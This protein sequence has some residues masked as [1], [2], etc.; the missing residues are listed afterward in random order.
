M[1]NP[2][3]LNQ[4]KTSPS[5]RENTSARTIALLNQKGGVGKTTTTINL[6]AALALAEQRVLLVDLDPQAHLM[7]HLG[8]DEA[9]V[10]HT[11]YDLLIDPEVKAADAIVNARPNLD[12]LLSEVDLAGAEPELA[13]RPDRQQ[14]LK[15]KIE[16]ILD[17]YDVIL[18]DCPPSLGLMTLNALACAREV[19]VPMQAHFLALQGVSKLLETVGL[20]CQSVNP[21]LRVSGIILCMHEAQTTL[22]KE[23][24]TDLEDFFEQASQQDVPWSQCR[25]LQPPIRRNIKLAEAPSFGETIFDYSPWCKG[26]IDYRKLARQLV[27]H[28]HRVIAPTAEVVEPKAE[29]PIPVS[30]PE[31]AQ[32]P[33]S[34]VVSISPPASDVIPTTI[35]ETKPDTNSRPAETMEA[36]VSSQVGESGDSEGTGDSGD[37]G[38]SGGSGESG[39]DVEPV[40]STSGTTAMTTPDCDIDAAER[41]MAND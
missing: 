26:A 37:S 4:A 32:A 28:W 34:T 17:R 40:V 22:A 25:V 21:D 8:I 30:T 14:I 2:S 20:V 39:G 1:M 9:V 10:E 18:L 33:A 23:I 31:P 15:R 12:V 38:D 5:S 16:P 36:S 7:L 6:G 29:V 41:T 3:I 19:F 24:V 27:E 11:V 13:Q 35:V